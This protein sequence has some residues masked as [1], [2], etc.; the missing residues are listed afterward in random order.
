MPPTLDVVATQLIEAACCALGGDGTAAQEHI[1]RALVILRD[2]PGQ[3]PALLHSSARESLQEVAGALSAWRAQ[4]VAAYIENHL[5][6]T[7][8]VRDLAHLVGLSNSYFC[9][10]FK[11]RYGLTVHVYL[12]CRRI[13]TAQRLM[14][15]TNESLSEIALNCGMSDQAH[16]TRAFRRI[17]GETPNRWRQSQRTARL[18]GSVREVPG[19]VV[20]WAGSMEVP[21]DR[22]T[23]EARLVGMIRDSAVRGGRD[24]L[25]DQA[26]L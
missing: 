17:V 6:G 25:P 7:I 22:S 16:F 26:R 4:K 21:I 24:D 10:A 18:E 15:A 23:V 11:R 3:A 13:E 5:S 19:D 14:L 1:A 9:H 20:A 2:R 8:R 12:T